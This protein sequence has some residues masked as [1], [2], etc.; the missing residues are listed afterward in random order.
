MNLEAT[1]ELPAPPRTFLQWIG[2]ILR[3][4]G[5]SLDPATRTEPTLDEVKRT[6]LR[7]VRHALLRARE[8]EERARHTVSMLVERERRLSRDE[9]NPTVEVPASPGR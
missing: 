7:A 4:A 6:Q 2:A 3:A 8:D 1:N 5:E 9:S